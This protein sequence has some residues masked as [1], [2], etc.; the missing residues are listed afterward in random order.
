MQD[1]QH[2]TP[3]QRELE[4]A[5][6]SLAPA[7]P[8]IDRDR[9]L[10]HAGLAAGRSACRRWAAAATAAAV[11]LAAVLAVVATFPRGATERIVYVRPAA[12]KPDRPHRLEP[13]TVQVATGDAARP[14]YLRLRREVLARGLGALPAAASAGGVSE[15]NEEYRQLLSR[16]AAQ[17][18]GRL[19]KLWTFL[20]TGDE[21]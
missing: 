2:L 12:A 10:Y 5:L 16:P 17:P 8:G 7:G 19:L 3:A 1:E 11:V 18:L 21:S 14:E 9:L 15:M 13:W 20:H 4:A 6:A